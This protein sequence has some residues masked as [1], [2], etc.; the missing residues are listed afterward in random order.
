MTVA[1]YRGFV[2]QCQTKAGAMAAVGLGWT[3]TS[4][5]LLSGAVIA[6]DNSLSNV[7]ISGDE[8]AVNATL[9]RIESARTGVFARK[10]KV[11]KAYHSRKCMVC[12]RNSK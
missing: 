2:S 5:H 10:L 1:Y 6:C 4:L 12:T 9:S 3:D 8:D 11:D 7:T